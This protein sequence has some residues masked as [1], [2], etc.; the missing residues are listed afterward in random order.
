MTNDGKELEHLVHLI[1]RS[2][3]SNSTLEHN[4]QLPVIGSPSGRT[5]QCDIVIRTG[6]KP[7]ETIT[8]VEV[9]DRS[10]PV[11]QTMFDGWLSKMNEVGA[12][13]LICV[14]RHDY[15]ISVREKALNCGNTVRLIT[16]KELNIDSIP[17]NF[18][19][20]QFIYRKFDVTKF[21]ISVGF[22][23]AEVETLCIRD[24]VL[25]VMDTQLS[26]N[27]RCWS[28]D[29]N[30]ALSLFELCSDFFNVPVGLSEG[31]GEISFVRDEEPT[32]FM[33]VDGHFFRV[34]IDC[35][36]QWT[37]KITRK[38]ANILSYEQNDEGTLAWVV[39]A[40]HDTESGQISFKAPVIKCSEGYKVQGILLNLPSDHSV[41]IFKCSPSPHPTLSGLR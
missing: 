28:L 5:R 11:D 32:L 26:T 37:E 3:D 30:K 4:V 7:R 17:L 10:R 31:E 20:V 27:D 22:S 18:V 14:S 16:L 15:P 29:K 34:W 23:R 2:I 13:H 6:K 1:E 38:P 12:Q 36:F 8:I 40:S 9:Q 19:N 33:H 25:K 41:T 35:K 24:S 39:E 21:D